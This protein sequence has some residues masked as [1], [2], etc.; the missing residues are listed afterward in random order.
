MKHAR[1]AKSAAKSFTYHFFR[2]K[3]E[4]R[5]GV[6]EEERE[7]KEKLWRNLLPAFAR[8]GGFWGVRKKLGHGGSCTV[9]V[10]LFPYE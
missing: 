8:A 10:E 2:M 4:L 3:R 6:P 1:K 7:G 9:T 5:V